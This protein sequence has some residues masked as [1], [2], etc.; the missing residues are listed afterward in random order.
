M[1]SCIHTRPLPCRYKT[2]AI[3]PK[4]AARAT[5]ELRDRWFSKV[6]SYVR[7][8]FSEDKIP[9]ATF[10]DVPNRSKY[11]VD[12]MAANAARGRQ[13]A[14]L[15]I[16]PHADG[17]GRVFDLSSDGKMVRHVS[18]VAVT[19]AD[20]VLR[21]NGVIKVGAGDSAKVASGKRKRGETVRI[22]KPK[23]IDRL[24]LEDGCETEDNEVLKIKVMTSPTAS[25]TVEVFAD[26]WVDHFM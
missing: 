15:S 7:K 6:D 23:E 1:T 17:M 21:A 8:L 3:D 12:E 9:W 2:A 14:L 22:T 26:E 11:N 13:P 4:R 25:M 5:E 10:N 24:Y 19:R 20:G 18:D 16:N